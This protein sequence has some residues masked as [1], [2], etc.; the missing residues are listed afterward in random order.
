[1]TARTV[2][3]CAL[4]AGAVAGGIVRGLGA[5]H[6]LALLGAVVF[7]AA[8]GLGLSLLTALLRGPS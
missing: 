8:I 7:A 3:V 4:L 1:M 6:A 2:G 5:P